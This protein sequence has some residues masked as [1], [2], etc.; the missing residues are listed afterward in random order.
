VNGAGR[1]LETLALDLLGHEA[2]TCQNPC[3]EGGLSLVR[4]R[5]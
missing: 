5:G 4:K 3:D 1:L 2:L